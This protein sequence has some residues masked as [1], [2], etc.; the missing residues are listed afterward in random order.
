ME[1]I[2]KRILQAMT[3]GITTGCTGNCYVIIPDLT[4][5]YYV[6][7]CLTSDVRELGFFDVYVDEGGY[8]GYDGNNRSVENNTMLVSIEPIGLDNLMF[9]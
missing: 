6:K 4:A 3:T 9:S 5:N 1:I 2:K 7:I 8:D